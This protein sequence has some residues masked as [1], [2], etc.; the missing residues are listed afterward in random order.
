MSSI[1]LGID[2]SKATFDVALLN[3]NK[4]KTKKFN[5]TAKGFA[6]LK[7][8]LEKKG[9]DTA[10]ACMESTGGYEVRLAQYLYDN[11]FKVSVV[12]P[13]RIK[14]FAMSKLSRVKTDKSDCE[15]I[16]SFCK[17]M[18]PDLW[19]PTPIHIKELQQWVRRL[20]SLI[21][22]KNQEN[23]RLSGASKAVAINI[24]I[25]IEF[26][27]KQIKEVEELIS[28]HIKGHKDLHDKSKLLD[29][30]PGIGEKTIGVILAFLVVENFNSAKQLAAFVGLNPKPKQSGTSVHGIG[31]ISK[32]GD[33]N[34]RKAFYM[35]AIVAI[36]HNPIIKDFSQRLSNVGKSKMVIVIAAMRK[37]L[38]IIYGV[39]NNKT[40]FSANIKT[41]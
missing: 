14:G 28:N 36:K 39:L 35:P 3:D 40:S 7:Q 25:H 24:M 20:D 6:A 38:H 8:W 23:N 26:L 33:A 2:I 16:A 5:N 4:I 32:T 29:S 11:T 27:D 9:I 22:N 21:A 15:L 18:Q 17:A 34:L 30:I 10:H 31:K 19:Q 1:I 37:L 13:A 12:N 41:L